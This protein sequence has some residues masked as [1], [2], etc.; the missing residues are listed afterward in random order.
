LRGAV[1]FPT[2]DVGCGAEEVEMHAYIAMKIFAPALVTTP[3]LEMGILWD[4]YLC[5]LH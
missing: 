5:K 4:D 1:S 2:E 3:T